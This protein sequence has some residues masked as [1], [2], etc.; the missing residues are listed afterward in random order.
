MFVLFLGAK[1]LICRQFKFVGAT[2]FTYFRF[3]NI[4]GRLFVKLST[5]DKDYKKPKKNRDMRKVVLGALL[6]VFAIG[7]VSCG[8]GHTCDAYRQADYSEYKK[9]QN[10]RIEM[11][12]EL[13]EQTK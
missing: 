12:Q 6:G 9:E 1:L 2:F 8:G 13:T 10:Q 4:V 5:T 11:V 3:H 7:M